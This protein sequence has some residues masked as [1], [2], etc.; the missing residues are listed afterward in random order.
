MK[1][2]YF[3]IV[4]GYINITTQCTVQND[5]LQKEREREKVS[6]FILIIL[7]I[8]YINIIVLFEIIYNNYITIL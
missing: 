8:S 7:T 4:L 2:I 1:D 3:T 6:I 5:L